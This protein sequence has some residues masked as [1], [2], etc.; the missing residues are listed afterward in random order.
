MLMI[1]YLKFVKYVV[2]NKKKKLNLCLY[3]EKKIMWD[4][5]KYYLV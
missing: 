4:G 2:I 3:L 1:L 5:F